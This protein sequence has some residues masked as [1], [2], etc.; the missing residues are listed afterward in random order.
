MRVAELS[1]R[2]GYAK[3]TLQKWAREGK[4]PSERSP[5]GQ[6]RF[7]ESLVSQLSGIKN[8]QDRIPIGYCR[9][10]SQKQ[11]DDLQRQVELVRQYL[12][13]NG[14]RF[15]IITDIGSGINYRKEGLRK[16]LLYIASNKVD[17]II[18]LYRDRLLRFG[19]ELIEEFCSLFDC[20]LEV[21]DNTERTEQEELVEDLI[22]IITVFSCRLNGKRS[23]KSKKLLQELKDAVSSENQGQDD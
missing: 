5:G 21:I 1:H 15:E 17:R 19:N 7:S 13:A 4:I 8:I 6:F 2:T 9:V 20:K 14:Y 11:S 22:Q 23:H 18:V 12:V 3:I 16:L 10:S